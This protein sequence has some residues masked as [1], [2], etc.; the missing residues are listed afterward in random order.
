[1]SERTGLA[2]AFLARNGWG[3]AK[4][5]H[6]A[7]DASNRSYTRLLQFGSNQTAILMD[8]PPDHGE[9]VEPFIRITN[10]LNLT[11]LSAPNIFAKDEQN[12]FLLLE[13]FGDDLFATLIKA[14]PELELVLYGAAVDVLIQ[15]HQSQPPDGLL[16]YSPAVMAN[17]ISPVFD[18]YHSVISE[19]TACD[20]TGISTVLETVLTTHCSNRRVLALRDYHAENLLWLPDRDGIKRVGLLD[21]QDAVTAHPAYDLVS[22]LEDARRN[23]PTIIQESMIKRYVTA[24]QDDEEGFRIAYH[25]QG[26]QRNLRILGVFA[27]LCLVAGKADYIDLIPRVWAHLMNDLSHP[28]LSTLR[29]CVLQS[30][31]EPSPKIR[32]RLKDKCATIQMS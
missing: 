26:A 11:N 24:T 31:P 3:N 15:M 1:M 32:Q 8:A 18:W 14:N 9:T 28:A 4:K 25:A 21:Y 27:R 5:S 29:E 17:Y 2:N 19:N 7:G 20:H 30:L 16:D 22:L 12:G 13:D 6:L 23:V 10:H